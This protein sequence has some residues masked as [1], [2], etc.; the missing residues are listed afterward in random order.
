MKILI[1]TEGTILMHKNAAGLNREEIV[2]QV[3]N[4]EK[5]VH[6]YAS[7]I[8]IGNAVAK[9]KSWQNQGTE[10][11]YLTS[12]KSQKEI[13]EISEVLKQYNFPEGLLLNRKGNQEYKDIAEQIMPDILV[14]DDCESIG[15][16]NEMTYTHI[17]SD[18]KS[19]IKSV[20][21]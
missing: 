4:K 9:T 19:K 6:D 14:E 12:R 13:D 10:I 2:K 16:T 20:P 11:I 1:F 15:G 3:E 7:Y 5:S 8:P 21:I 18:L 17:R